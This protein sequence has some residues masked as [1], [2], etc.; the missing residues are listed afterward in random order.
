LEILH[1]KI[2]MFELV[3]GEMDMILGDFADKKSFESAVFH[4]WAAARNRRE[5]ERRFRELGDE[6]AVN[7]RRYEDVRRLDGEIFGG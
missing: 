6:L 3:I 5:L 4:I 7:R 2:D 1:R